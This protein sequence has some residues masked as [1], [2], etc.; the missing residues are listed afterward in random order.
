M[1]V[2]ALGGIDAERAPRR[3]PPARA[4]PAS[5]P[6]SGGATP[7]P[8]PARRAP[9]S[10][11]SDDA[12]GSAAAWI[13]L[14][15]ALVAHGPR[16]CSPST[17]RA[18]HRT[19]WRP[20]CA[21]ATCCSPAASAAAPARRRRAVHLARQR[22]AQHPP[23]HRR[24][25]RPRGGARGQML[26][27]GKPLG[28]SRRR[29][30]EARRHRPGVEPSRAPSRL[31]EER[32]ARHEYRVVR[33]HG[34]VSS[35]DRAGPRRS[36]TRTSWPPTGARWCA[37][38]AT[39][40]RCRAG[41]ALDGHARAAGG[42]P[43]RRAPGQAA[44][45]ASTAAFRL[46]APA[47]RSL[48]LPVPGNAPR[49]A[50]TGAAAGTGSG[51][52][53]G[54]G[55]GCGWDFTAAAPGRPRRRAGHSG[56]AGLRCAGTAADAA[57]AA[58]RARSEWITSRRSAHS[59]SDRMR[60]WHCDQWVSA[61]MIR[62]RRALGLRDERGQPGGEL[63]RVHVVGVVA[64]GVDLPRRIGRRHRPRACAARRAAAP[65]R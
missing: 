51:S 28:E 18:R 45:V 54:S 40:G 11:R 34:I 65:T 57:A 6:S 38:A 19:T 1:P 52:G 30:R 5:A 49:A 23:R 3:S 55:R 47:P 32:T 44:L 36:P 13:L 14:V 8:P 64:E 41:R 43:R 53:S 25:R 7:A 63:G 59:L 42:R 21:R 29:D 50:A 16:R 56:G 60:R 35:G 9:R 12:H 62:G 61:H 27:N 33:D 15:V 48:P 17:S 46:P 26:V 20:A 24:A 37:T 2:F 58:C 39:T 10:D 31:V 4:W 22:A